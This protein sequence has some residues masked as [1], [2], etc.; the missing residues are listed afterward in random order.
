MFNEASDF[1]IA[2]LRLSLLCSLGASAHRLLRTL[3]TL[4]RVSAYDALR[5][6]N[7]SF[8]LVA[9]I[10]LPSNI[11]VVVVESANE[12]ILRGWIGC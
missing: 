11:C 10:I 6:S 12:H 9:H 2:F 7:S 3:F 8:G 4:E 1:W 5:I